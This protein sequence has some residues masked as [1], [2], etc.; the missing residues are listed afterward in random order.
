M[1][2]K[3]PSNEMPMY[4]ICSWCEKECND[5]VRKDIAYRTGPDRWEYKKPFHKDSD[6]KTHSMCP[7]HSEIEIEKLK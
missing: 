3:T 4:V 7:Y 5:G 1:T 6:Q 2:W